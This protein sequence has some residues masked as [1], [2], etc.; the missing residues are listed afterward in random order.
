MSRKM[1][2]EE[3]TK[4]QPRK[5]KPRVNWQRIVACSVAGLLAGLMIFSVLSDFMVGAATTQKTVNDLKDKLANTT[6]R[7]KQLESELSSLKNNKGSLSSK[8]SKTDEQLSAAEEEL[9]TQQLL[10]DELTG[11]IET[12]EIELADSQA[13]EDAQYEK[14][15]MRVR[16]LYES[17]DLSYLGI[18]LSAD[19]F[20][21][22]LNRY[23]IISQISGYEKQMFDDL[24]AIKENIAEQKLS[25]ETDK[26]QQ[27]E[28]KAALVQNK[29]ELDTRRAAQAKE[30][31]A[32]ETAEAAAKEAYKEI[33]AEEDRVQAEIKKAIAALASQSG[34]VGGT[35]LWPLPASNTRITCPYGMRVHPITGVYKLH[36]GVDIGASRGTKIFAANGGTVITSA[37]SSAYGNYVVINH[38]GG[39]STLYAHMTKRAVGKGDKVTKGDVIGYVGSTGYST[40]P[41]LHFEIVKNGKTINPM[42]E[43]KKK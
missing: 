19:D 1:Q 41:H 25:L 10:I 15:R 40:G 12:K 21:D 36:T 6:K 9:E 30:L 5:Q 18:L 35:F 24:K 8:I 43:F 34:Y 33:D 37:Y 27:L 31:K 7:K 14:M 38:G 22:F 29:K 20:G 16:F 17:G 11:L 13:K 23:E 32:L 28:L 26:A 3:K 39:V 2:T 4:A 42:T